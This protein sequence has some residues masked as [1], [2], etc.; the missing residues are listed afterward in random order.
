ML[1]LR[2]NKG[3]YIETTEYLANLIAPSRL[4]GKIMYTEQFNNLLI[5]GHAKILKHQPYL[6]HNG[7]YV[8]IN[9]R[10]A[11]MADVDFS[12]KGNTYQFS[13]KGKLESIKNIYFITSQSTASASELLISLFKPYFNVKTV[14]QKTF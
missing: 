12:E 6:D 3:G 5:S 4:N 2:Y 14:G 1:D 8:K 7:N 11:T 9:G 10:Q 13:K